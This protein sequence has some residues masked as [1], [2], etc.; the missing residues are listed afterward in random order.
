MESDFLHHYAG[1]EL[2]LIPDRHRQH[3]LVYHC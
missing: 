1:S 3:R 2:S